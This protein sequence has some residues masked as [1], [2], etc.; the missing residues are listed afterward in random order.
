MVQEPEYRTRSYLS[1]AAEDRQSA[2]EE[3]M[4]RGDI[5][6]M[7]EVYE[8]PRATKLDISEFSKQVIDRYDQHTSDG[9]LTIDQMKQRAVARSVMGTAERTGQPSVRVANVAREAIAQ[10]S[11]ALADGADHRAAREAASRETAKRFDG[12]ARRIV[13][14]AERDNRLS[15]DPIRLRNEMIGK[16]SVDV[17]RKQLDEGA[18]YQQAQA[19]AEKRIGLVV[20]RNGI[21]EDRG[22]NMARHAIEQYR[23]GIDRGLGETSARDRAVSEVG[24][25]FD[26]RG[27]VRERLNG[28]SL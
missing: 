5:G 18:S 20:E 10:Y 1:A 6:Q 9:N 19:I 8:K 12:E 26:D 17:Y 11:T 28:M 24:K 4:R 21:R 22:S 15:D 16:I 23:K 13:P 2:L 14:Q 7:R 3:A 25:T 27:R